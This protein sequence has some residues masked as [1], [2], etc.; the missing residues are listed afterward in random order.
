MVE[1]CSPVWS[2]YLVRDVLL[3]ESV[4]RVFT[5][6]IPGLRDI[7]Y[8]QR[9]TLLGVQTLE[10]RR[11]EQDLVTCYKILHGLIKG[12][13]ETFGL[14]LSNRQSLGHSFKLKTEQP[15][16]DVRKFFFASRVAGP[17]NS[18]PE[19]LVSADTVKCFKTKLKLI[20]LNDYLIVK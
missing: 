14:F 6:R 15:R 12:P 3:V 1:Y 13:P 2:P 10:R 17:W 20:N 9:V 18:L 11:L 16:V 7:P 19:D 5:K 4:Q 8:I